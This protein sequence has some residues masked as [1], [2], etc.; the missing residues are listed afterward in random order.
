[1]AS[2]YSGTPLAKKLGIKPGDEV[3]TAHAP[4][5]SA[6]LTAGITRSAD[7]LVAFCTERATL[8]DEHDGLAVAVF[9]DN[10]LRIAWP[11]KATKAATDLNRELVRG[12]ALVDVN[13]CAI[14]TAWP[15]LKFMWRKEHRAGAG[16]KIR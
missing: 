6:A 13:V 3:L 4:T 8:R 9:P 5:D 2:G 10:I 15:G 1:M 11:E 12:T 14:S 16:G 7:V